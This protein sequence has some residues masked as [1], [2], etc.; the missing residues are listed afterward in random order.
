[1]HF[2]GHVDHNV[3]KFM[4]VLCNIPM[5]IPSAI[6]FGRYHSDHHN[7]LGELRGD[8]D[9]PLP[10]EAKI[11]KEVKW[12]KYFFYIFIEVFYALRPIFM[13]NPSIRLD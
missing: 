2:G 8:P 4:A 13:T 1:M 11:S 7:F 9:L 3:N 12:Y 10:W 5:A 6:S